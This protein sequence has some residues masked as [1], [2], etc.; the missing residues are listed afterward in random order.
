MQLHCKLWSNFLPS[1]LLL[2]FVAL[3]C[4]ALDIPNSRVISPWIEMFTAPAA[5]RIFHI[6]SSSNFWICAL[7]RMFWSGRILLLSNLFLFVFHA[8]I[9]FSINFGIVFRM[10]MLIVLLSKKMKT[11][12]ARELLWFSFSFSRIHGLREK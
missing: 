6:S 1:R 10:F 11:S 3:E 8:S 9:K 4:F 5:F 12:T 2:F 7:F